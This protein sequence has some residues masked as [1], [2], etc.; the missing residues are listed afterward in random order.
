LSSILY[1]PGASDCAAYFRTPDTALK[2]L[3]NQEVL[4]QLPLEIPSLNNN[5]NKK[6]TTDLVAFSPGH[7]LHH[8]AT[9]LVP[10]CH[11]Q[12]YVAERYRSLD[13][14]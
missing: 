8:Q 7:F 10:A 14:L 9:G 2:R 4:I 5:A 3:K 6:A 1:F 13:H 12:V 11:C